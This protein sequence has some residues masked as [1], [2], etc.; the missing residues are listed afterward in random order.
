MAF[1]STSY[2][3]ACVRFGKDAAS[4]QDAVVQDAVARA[5]LFANR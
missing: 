2:M 4:L 5:V 1:A 3:W